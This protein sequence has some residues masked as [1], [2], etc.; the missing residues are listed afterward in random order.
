MTPI[1]LER[2]AMRGQLAG[3]IQTRERLRNR[4]KGEAS[5]IRVKLNLTLTPADDLDVPVLDE[6]WDALK[7]AWA[8]LISTNQG[9]RELEKE[10]L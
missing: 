3:L 9:I 10:L 2:A 6:Q 5:A 8:E 1:N 7:A 4:I